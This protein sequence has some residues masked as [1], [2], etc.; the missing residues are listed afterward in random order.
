MLLCS[1][2]LKQEYEDEGKVGMN[3][4][5]KRIFK[6]FFLRFLTFDFCVTVQKSSH[7]D[8]QFLRFFP[9]SLSSFFRSPEK[10]Q[11]SNDVIPSL[12]V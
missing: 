4:L 3:Q 9:R 10:Q 6:E 1:T 11:N 7:S 5:L 2:Y 12:N 8:L